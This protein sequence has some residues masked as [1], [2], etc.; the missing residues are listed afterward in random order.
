MF[1]LH[2]IIWKLPL[3]SL[4]KWLRHKLTGHKFIIVFL[5]LC[6][7]TMWYV[8]WCSERFTIFSLLI[9]GYIFVKVWA[10]TNV[11]RLEPSKDHQSLESKLP[12]KSLI[13]MVTF[14]LIIVRFLNH[15]GFLLC[16]AIVLVLEILSRV[17]KIIMCFWHFSQ[18]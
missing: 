11:E 17:K 10:I 14:Q 4:L 15:I 12:F 18:F 5:S 6:F 9:C 2:T 7:C 16:M 3:F 13:T 1:N 8:S